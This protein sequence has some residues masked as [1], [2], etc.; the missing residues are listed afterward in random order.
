[1]INYEEAWAVI[2]DPKCCKDP[3]AVTAFLNEIGLYAAAD[4]SL[5]EKE[6]LVSLADQFK[7]VPKKKLHVIL[8]MTE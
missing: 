2:E 6:T 1:V 3:Q 5:V 7:A 4:L 8:K